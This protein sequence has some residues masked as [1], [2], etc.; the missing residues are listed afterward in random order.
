MKDEAEI[1]LGQGDYAALF[2]LGGNIIREPDLDGLLKKILEESRPWISCEA[3]SIF[4]LDE[5][6][7]ELLILSAYGNTADSMTEFRMPAGQGIVGTAMTEKCTIRVDDVRTDKRFYSAAD[8]KTGWKTRALVAAPLLDGDRAIGAIEFLN[9]IG[10]PAFTRNDELLI[11]YFS[12]L[13][14]ASLVR[15]QS[16]RAALERAQVQRDLD[17]AREIQ[18]GI[19]PKDFPSP[20]LIGGL[21]LYAVIHPAKEVSGDL[22]DFFLGPDGRLYFL[23]GDVSGKGVAPGLFMAISRTM[24]RAIAGQGLGPME[25]L[26]AANAQLWPENPTFL[27]VTIALGLYDSDN[28]TIHY[29]QAGHCQAVLIKQ[30]GKAELQPAGGQPLGVFEDAEFSPLSCKLELGDTFVLYSDGV[31]EAMNSRKELYGDTRLLSVLGNVTGLSSRQICEKMLED[32]A[33]FVN[34]AEQSDDITIM[35]LRR[36]K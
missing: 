15:I 25:L 36:M 31:T 26:M 2:A 14:S 18:S 28:S 23:V 22:Y 30:N 34:R 8:Q 27:F 1:S 9:P 32:V 20:E 33:S 13:V 5:A 29:A 19:L 3:C 7:G 6:T 24:I 21:D 4:L 17:L 35:V 10:R 11:D 12:T 16:H